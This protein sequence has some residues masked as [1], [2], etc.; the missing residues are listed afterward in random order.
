MTKLNGWINNPAATGNIILKWILYC[1]KDSLVDLCPSC[2]Q[3]LLTH[4]HTLI[5]P[6]LSCPASP[7]L[8]VLP[9]IVFKSMIYTPPLITSYVQSSTLNDACSSSGH[10]S[11]KYTTGIT[12]VTC[13]STPRWLLIFLL[14]VDSST[15]PSTLSLIRSSFTGYLIAWQYRCGS[16]SLLFPVLHAP[17]LPP[18]V[19]THISSLYTKCLTKSECHSSMLSSSFPQLPV[20]SQWFLSWDAIELSQHQKSWYTMILNPCLKN[21]FCFAC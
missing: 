21:R 20:L 7:L 1:L 17:F 15:K 14:S 6:S 16:C 8:S 4:S 19:I 18:L 11:S 10:Q 13:S 12:S 3:W 2:P 9:E 5:L